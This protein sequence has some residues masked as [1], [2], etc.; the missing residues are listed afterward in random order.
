M[1]SPLHLDRHTTGDRMAARRKSDRPRVY[2]CA[3]ALRKRASLIASALDNQS[4]SVR[5][6]LPVRWPAFLSYH[7]LNSDEVQETWHGVSGWIQDDV[8]RYTNPGEYINCSNPVCYS[9]GI[10]LGLPIRDMVRARE[11]EKEGSKLCQGSE[12][13]PKGRRIYRKC[14]NFFKYKITIKYRTP[15]TKIGD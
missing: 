15:E 8:G 6:T 4:Q 10:K 11:T 13:F 2:L 9:G 12:G 7:R 3:G 1:R 5:K 14:A